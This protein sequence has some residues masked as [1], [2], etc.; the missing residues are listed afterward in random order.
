[1]AA[2]RNPRTDIHQRIQVDS[3][4][5]TVATAGAI[6]AVV[7][8]S[9]VVWLIWLSGRL[10]TVPHRW[11]FYA[12]LQIALTGTALPFVRLLNRRF[13]RRRALY[14]RAGV[15]VRQAIWVGLFGT[16]CAWLRIP[17]LLSVPMASVVALALI[18]IE[19][20]LRLRERTEWRPG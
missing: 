8:W 18:A 15:I 2:Q 11:V 9:G 12:L 5:I 6:L 17:R 20:L 13:S 7:G 19:A 10:P 1:M 4:H 16:T 3:D 14:V